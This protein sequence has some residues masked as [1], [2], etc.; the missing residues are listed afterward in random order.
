MNYKLL[1]CPLCGF[2]LE[3]YLHDDTQS[4]FC[5]GSPCWDGGASCEQC[6]VSFC[7]GMFGGGISVDQA[8][9]Y[10]AKVLNRRPK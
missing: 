4:K 2:E 1:P 8:E 5:N 9:K 3:L 6:G 10:I 7:V